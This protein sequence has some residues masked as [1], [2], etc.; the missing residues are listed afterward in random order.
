MR[1]LVASLQMSLDGVIESPEVWAFPFSS[2]E[3]KAANAAGMAASDALLLGRVT[4]QLLAG[5]WP[6]RPDEE[7]I[8]R[9]INAVPKFV[10]SSVLATVEWRH[11][12]LIKGNV[13]DEIAALKDQPGKNITIV[14][15][16]MLVRS[17]LR[18]GLLDQLNLMIPPLVVGH[19][20]RLFEDGG[21]HHALRLLD[22]T[23]FSTGVVSLTYEP[24]NARATAGQG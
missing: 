10:V 8:A 2:D 23:T 5:Y 12:T 18:A 19:G 14:G 11:S 15:S 4:Y 22:A 21:D 1:R 16:A 6:D 24:A 7:S 3:M 9:Y 13:I 20:K 17:V